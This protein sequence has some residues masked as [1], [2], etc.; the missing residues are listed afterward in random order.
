[1][2]ATFDLRHTSLARASPQWRIRKKS[3][4][5]M[6]QPET[7]FDLP[8]LHLAGRA[9]LPIVQGGM[10]VGVSAHR[11]AG[12]V[13]ACDAVGT[14]S[15]V[16]LRRHYPDL[17]ARTTHL[18]VGA[19]AKAAINAANLEALDRTVRA[20]RALSQG[21]GLLA[22]NV[23][24][25]VSEYA[26]Y[27]R[28]ACASGIDAVVVGAGL[29]LDLPELAA[30]FPRVALIPILSD[31]RGIA[32]IL[33]KW[34]R[35]GR[36][37]DAIV[38]EHPKHAGGHLGA[39]R[40]E[41]LS[42]PRFDFE[43]VL[44]EARALLRALGAEERVP[45]IPAGGIN[46][47]QRVRELFALGASAVQV[48]TAFAVTEEGDAHPEFKRALAEAKPEDIV[49]FM[50]V[51]GLPARAVRTPWLNAYLKVEAKMQ[52][53]TAQRGRPKPRCTMVFDCL[54][55]CGLRDGIAKFGQFC[56]DHQLAAALRG[57]L[58]KGLFFRGAGRLPFGSQIRPVR[59]LIDYLLTLTPAL[60]H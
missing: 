44:P 13:A 36:L 17:M 56:I 14:L 3:V 49:E 19:E 27:V 10:G 22:V 60:S 39:A 59:E 7:T 45:L 5:A 2:S 20:A 24:R 53:K 43:N 23:M 28:Q 38:I 35:K 18:G 41:D 26:P 54:A 30:D 32:L 8:L 33:K 46:T 25:A 16:D 37:P 6:N 21:R 47:P 34:E 51:A 1:M 55:Q 15:S 29:P 9:V 52:A 42:D 58:K 4:T 11:L 50:S 48:G 12:S 40:I 31:A 57:D